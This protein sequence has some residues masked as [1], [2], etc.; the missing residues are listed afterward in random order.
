M[1][2]TGVPIRYVDVPVPRNAGCYNGYAG[3]GYG[4]YGYGYGGYGYGGYSYGI[5]SAT[6]INQPSQRSTRSS[7]A[8]VSQPAPPDPRSA[9]N[10][11]LRK[12]LNKFARE[13]SVGGRLYVAYDSKKWLLEY[14][15]TP[16]FDEDTVTIPCIGKAAGGSD[17]RLTL[18]L[19]FDQLDDVTA[20]VGPR[21]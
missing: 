20:E 21:G 8:R 15:G 11:E 14:D 17:H 10:Y 19:R 18:T 9:R 16:S 2:A 12:A 13:N 5:G 7:A 4:G 3:Y 1:T 6:P